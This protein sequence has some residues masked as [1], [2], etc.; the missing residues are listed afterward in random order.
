MRAVINIPPPV[1]EST[2]DLIEALDTNLTAICEADTGE[3][4]DVASTVMYKVCAVRDFTFIP[5]ATAM[6]QELQMDVSVGSVQREIL[7]AL[8]ILDQIADEN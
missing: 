1:S 2:L 8:I 3:A 5:T 4:H 6:L 7:S